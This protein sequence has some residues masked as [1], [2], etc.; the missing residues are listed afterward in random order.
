MPPPGVRRRRR[1][2]SKRPRAQHSRHGTSRPAD[3]ALVVTGASGCS[4]TP[5]PATSGRLPRSSWIPSDPAGHLDR[6]GLL[7][8]APILPTGDGR[9]SRRP[10]PPAASAAWVR[11]GTSSC[12]TEMPKWMRLRW[13]RSQAREV[14]P[15]RMETLSGIAPEPAVS[16][17][18]H[19]VSRTQ[20]GAD[21]GHGAV[22]HHV[23]RASP[24]SAGEPGAAAH[25]PCAPAT[26]PRMYCK[27]SIDSLAL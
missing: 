9:R 23:L 17:R 12:G 26:P 2:G 3:S 14:D 19:P 6:S 15:T 25:S 1:R 16:G 18:R 27:W 13:G 8:S 4:R 22:P 21:P 10:A 24:E 20:P 7:S 11:L 5:V